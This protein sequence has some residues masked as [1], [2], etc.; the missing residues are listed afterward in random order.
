MSGLGK[1]LKDRIVAVHEA[2]HA[3]WMEILGERVESTTINRHETALGSLGEVVGDDLSYPAPHVGIKL[4]AGFAS[5]QLFCRPDKKFHQKMNEGEWE[6]T[7]AIFADA[8]NR[9]A[10][11]R[12]D[13]EGTRR[14]VEF[15]NK[16]ADDSDAPQI[17]AD[18]AE[19]SDEK[20]PTQGAMETFARLAAQACFY[21]VCSVMTHD[22]NVRK[23]ILALSEALLK[24]RTMT[25][26]EVRRVIT[27]YI[28]PGAS[29]GVP[30]QEMLQ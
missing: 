16:W 28:S 22:A 1:K 15:W 23:A 29:V 18:L 25:G 9:A 24:K 27:K 7:K 21:G 20:I 26:D 11:E 17:K 4:V 13:F 14:Q 6:R 2:G 8:Y 10:I 12:H 5:E 3:V 19:F 30:A